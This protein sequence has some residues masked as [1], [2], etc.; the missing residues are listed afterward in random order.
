MI[1]RRYKKY[2]KMGNHKVKAHFRI[3]L[4]ISSNKL[5]HFFENPDKYLHVGIAQIFLE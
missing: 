3:S 1:N 4:D 5:M 2:E